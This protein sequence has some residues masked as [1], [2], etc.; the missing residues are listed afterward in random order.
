MPVARFLESVP[1]GVRI[2]IWVVPGSSRDQIVGIHG[3]RLKVRVSPPAIDGRANLAVAALLAEAIGATPRLV[4]GIH[5]RSKVFEILGV[6]VDE[7]VGNLG[8]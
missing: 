4:R 2:S 6:S 5:S 1:G 8:V 3:D 7:V